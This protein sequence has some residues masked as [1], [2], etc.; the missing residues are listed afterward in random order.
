MDKGT[1]IYQELIDEFAKKSQECVAS[2][3]ALHGEAKG[4]DEHI[5]KLNK[6]FKKLSEDERQ[7]LAQYALE[8]YTDGIYDTLCEIEW[9]VDC[10]DMT[11]TVEGEQLPTQK[12]EGI[13]ND[14]IGRRDGDWD[15]PEE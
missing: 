4:T 11:I 9:Y 6:L 13:G 8:A 12:F 5:R 14:F 10:R 2:N 15:W 3:W 7:T 1:Q